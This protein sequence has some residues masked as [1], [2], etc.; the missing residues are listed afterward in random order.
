M[1][2]KIAYIIYQNAVISGKSNGVRNQAHTWCNILNSFGIECVLINNWE[3][4]DWDSFGAIHIFGYDTAIYSFVSSLSKKNPNLFLSPIIDSNQ[5]FFNYK[6]ATFNGYEPL[7]LF[8]VNF[9]LR[10]ALPFSKAVCVRTKHEGKYF[11]K[12]FGLNTGSVFKVPLSYGLQK[13]DDLGTILHQKENFCLHISSLY[14]DRKNVKRLVEAAKKYNF[15]L[16]LAGSKGNTADFKPIANAIG[17][18]ANITVLGY[19]SNEDLIEL[20][21]KA[22][23]FALPSTNEGVGIVALDA[24]LYGCNI[25]MTNIEGPKEYYP[26]METVAIVNPYDVDDIG[27]K[28]VKLLETKSN[29]NL[30]SFIENNYSSEQVFKQLLRMY[31]I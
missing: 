5:S 25:A 22:K 28:I 20:Y 13:P 8:S 23:V 31:N 11:T 10:K 14:Q 30:S 17:N 15:K 3:D 29:G 7:R 27:E 9:A 2:I 1:K 18:A 6:L 19:L 16:V 21:S 12:S 26:N 24:A 4:Y